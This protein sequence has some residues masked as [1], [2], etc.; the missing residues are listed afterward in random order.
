MDKFLLDLAGNIKMAEAV[1]KEVGTFVLEYNKRYLES[2]GIVGEYFA[3]WD[4]VAM[5]GGMM[6]APTDFKKY[7]LPIWK[8]LISMVKSK[9]MIFSW[10]CCGNANDVLR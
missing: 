9:N 10:H 5:Q 1:V 4:D 6:F 7:F 2:P 3:T 8:S